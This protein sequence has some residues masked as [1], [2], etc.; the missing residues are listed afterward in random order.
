MNAH[1]V[2]FRASG[3]IARCTCG[4]Q[5]LAKGIETQRRDVI[6]AAEDHA[7]DTAGRVE[8]SGLGAA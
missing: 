3:R 6:N 4:W 2:R 8:L 1:V 5:L 7:F